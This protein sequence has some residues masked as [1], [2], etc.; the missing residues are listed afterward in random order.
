[1]GEED[2]VWAGLGG[3][4][5]GVGGW[6]EGL[7]CGEDFGGFGFEVGGWWEDGPEGCS[8]GSQ[9][10]DLDGGCE[11]GD[12]EGVEGVGL[13]AVVGQ[14]GVELGEEGGAHCKIVGRGGSV[15]EDSDAAQLGLETTTIEGCVL[16]V[17]EE[18]RL[19]TRAGQ[20]P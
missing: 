17:A 1:M 14:D 6:V 4:G 11:E 18:E 16:C 2:P 12:W 20:G 7:D 10:V 8:A 5:F 13:V 9:V 3:S 19:H 15:A